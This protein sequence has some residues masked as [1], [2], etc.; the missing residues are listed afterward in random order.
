MKYSL[1]AKCWSRHFWLSFFTRPFLVTVYILVK[2]TRTLCK[3][4]L[5][6]LQ[7]ILVPL[8]LLNLITEDVC[9]VNARDRTSLLLGICENTN[10]QSLSAIQKSSYLV[11]SR[12]DQLATFILCPPALLPLMILNLLSMPQSLLISIDLTFWG[13]QS[14]QKKSNGLL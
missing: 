1:I 2:K 11:L 13:N 9:R 5:L 6:S 14:K 8:S 10:L 4:I 3:L 12:T 7:R